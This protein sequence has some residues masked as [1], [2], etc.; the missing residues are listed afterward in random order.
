M[1]LSKSCPDQILQN[2]L[3]PVSAFRPVSALR[4]KKTISDSA[5]WRSLSF[6][7]IRHKQLTIIKKI[8]LEGNEKRR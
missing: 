6:S 4:K 7:A 5:I 2:I 3:N 8:D 1:R